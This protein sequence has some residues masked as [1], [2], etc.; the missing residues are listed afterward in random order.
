MPGATASFRPHLEGRSRLEPVPPRV[1]W[2]A[3]AQPV[4]WGARQ[5]RAAV[6][7][8]SVLTFRGQWVD[9]LPDPEPSPVPERDP[10]AQ[11]A[12]G[13]AMPLRPRCA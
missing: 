5:G 3:G 13:S 8:P 2:S 7:P 10:R 1:P 6:G 11:P 12:A 4:Q 9:S